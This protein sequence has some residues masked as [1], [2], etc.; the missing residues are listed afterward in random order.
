MLFSLW[1]WWF[2]WGT[3][4]AEISIVYLCWTGFFLEKHCS[5]VMK[6]LS[7]LHLCGEV[8]LMGSYGRAH[9]HSDSSRCSDS[10]LSVS[11]LHALGGENQEVRGSDGADILAGKHSRFSVHGPEPPACTHRQRIQLL[12]GSYAH[13]ERYKMLQT[14]TKLSH[15]EQWQTVHVFQVYVFQP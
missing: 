9:R 11:R 15:V 7:D 14:N 6:Q 2:P 8:K 10:S 5:N 12:R 3:V 4:E 1:A 13:T